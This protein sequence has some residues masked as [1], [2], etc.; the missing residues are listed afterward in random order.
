MTARAAI[1][2]FLGLMLA[3]AAALEVALS[4]VQ[5]DA[6]D[7]GF[8]SQPLVEPAARRTPDDRHGATAT[9]RDTLAIVDHAAS[10]GDVSSAVYW[11]RTAYAEA[12]AT[13]AWPPMLE[14]GDAVLRLGRSTGAAGGYDREAREAYMVALVRARREG[15]EDGV[16][17]VSR[18]FE[19]LG[20]A[21]MAAE[22]RDLAVRIATAAA[23]PY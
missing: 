19:R 5:I 23:S 22:T 18:A 2:G 17:R 15:S 14:V 7:P 13:R 20:D 3:T 4:H 6:A 1:L 12:L 10:V 8:H 16:M 9:W 11:W 21:R